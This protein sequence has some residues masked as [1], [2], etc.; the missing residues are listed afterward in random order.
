[1]KKLFIALCALALMFGAKAQLINNENVRNLQPY[2][3]LGLNSMSVYGDDADGWKSKTGYSLLVG[4][5]KEITS[6]TTASL[7]F[8]MEAGLRSRGYGITEKDGSDKYEEFLFSHNIYLSPINLDA[9]LKVSNDFSLDAHVG[10]YAAYD[11]YG[12]YVTKTKVSGTTDK[13]STS[14]G[15]FDDYKR[16]DVGFTFGFGVW[17]QKFN[18]DVSFQKGF[19]DIIE[20]VNMRTNNVVFSVGYKL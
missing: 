20:D 5:Q 3:R 17:Y 19:V 11:Y 7:L 13:N 16:H 8:E 2:V 14:I 9:F 6:S 10:V 15:D 12:N 4:F 1:M 18:F